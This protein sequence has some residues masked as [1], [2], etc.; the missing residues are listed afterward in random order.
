MMKDLVRTACE[1]MKMLAGYGGT[2][3]HK[4]IRR[5]GVRIPLLCCKTPEYIGIVQQD[6]EIFEGAIKHRS[7]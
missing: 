5:R 2:P 3:E 4:G 1:A 7:V 6:A